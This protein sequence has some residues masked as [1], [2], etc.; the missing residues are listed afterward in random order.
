MIAFIHLTIENH[1]N[2][3]LNILG[4]CN[5]KTNFQYHTFTIL[6][7]FIMHLRKCIS[8]LNIKTSLI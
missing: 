7:V 6:L 5:Q 1:S 2:Q 8:N 4:I 3:N